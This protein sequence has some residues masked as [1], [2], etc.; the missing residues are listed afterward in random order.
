L[1]SE[2]TPSREEMA[3]YLEKLFGKPVSRRPI[4]RIEVNPPFHGQGRRF[5]TVGELSADLEPGAP[6]ETV[7][8]IFESMSY[9]V[10]T[11]E[12]GAGKGMPYIFTRDAVVRVDGDSEQTT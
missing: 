10:C 12:R 6:S 5:V 1:D 2:S 8:A 4:R 7:L 11:A 3:A 9:L